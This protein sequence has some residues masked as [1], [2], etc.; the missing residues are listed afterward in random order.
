MCGHWT[1]SNSVKGKTVKQN[2]KVT[3]I[4]IENL[5]NVF[6]NLVICDYLPKEKLKYFKINIDD[7]FVNIFLNIILSDVDEAY[8]HCLRKFYFICIHFIGCRQRKPMGIM[9]NV[10]SVTAMQ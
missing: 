1:V 9:K 4:F 5:F 10:C 2:L 3:L 8:N 6:P 7:S